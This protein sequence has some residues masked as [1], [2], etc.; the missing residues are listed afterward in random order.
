MSDSTDP[1]NAFNKQMANQDFVNQLRVSKLKIKLY[2]FYS[3]IK[4]DIRK[5]YYSISEIRVLA[6]YLFNFFT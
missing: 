2:G 6:K 4:S 3:E 1:I 5:L